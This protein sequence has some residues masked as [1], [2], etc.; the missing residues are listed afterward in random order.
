MCKYI[1]K[2]K[3]WF[4]EQVTWHLMRIHSY[5]PTGRQRDGEMTGW[6]GQEVM[7]AGKEECVR[8][9]VSPRLQRRLQQE[10]T[11]PRWIPMERLL[12]LNIQCTTHTAV[13]VSP[14]SHGNAHTAKRRT[15]HTHAA[16]SSTFIPA[17][18]SSPQV[19]GRMREIN[20]E[21]TP[22]AYRQTCWGWKVGINVRWK[23]LLISVFPLSLSLIW[24]SGEKKVCLTGMAESSVCWC[25]FSDLSEIE[26][27]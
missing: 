18:M 3:A 13:S 21:Q 1:E 2:K 6:N 17:Y 4:S 22:A 26:A 27:N 9:A 7:G 14:H 16:H 25:S 15:E 19:S 20:P 10:E 24:D 5:R 12:Q 23:L 11:D 8:S